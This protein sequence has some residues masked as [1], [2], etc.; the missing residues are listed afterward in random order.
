MYISYQISHH[1]YFFKKI[2]LFCFF[3]VCISCIDL[4]VNWFSSQ[5]WY[6]YTVLMD[7]QIKCK[8]LSR[9]FLWYYFIAFKFWR[10]F[11]DHLDWWVQSMVYGLA[12]SASPGNFLE[13]QILGPHTKLLYQKLWGWSPPVCVLTSP[14]SDSDAC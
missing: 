6:K 9:L 3:S 12:P 14:L 5:D 10:N 4:Y 1:H 2:S 8:P 11:G 7:V 13:A